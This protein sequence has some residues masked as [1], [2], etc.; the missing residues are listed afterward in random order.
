MTYEKSIPRKNEKSIPSKV[1]GELEPEGK[2][3]KE[4]ISCEVLVSA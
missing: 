1:V 2:E 4:T 3:A